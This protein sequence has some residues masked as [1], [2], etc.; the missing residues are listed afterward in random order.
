[1]NHSSTTLHIILGGLAGGLAGGLVVFALSTN[2]VDAHS[3][4][5]AE[6]PKLAVDS[7]VGDDPLAQRMN[8]LE[9]DV[10]LLEGQLMRM[11]EEV[12]QGPRRDVPPVD[13]KPV[14]AAFQDPAFQKN[15]LEVL[16]SRE[17]AQ[18]RERAERRIEQAKR[19]VDRRMER[20]TEDLALSP[21]QAQEMG[22][23]L[24]EQDQKVRD[25]FRGFRE[26]GGPSDQEEIRSTM[27][28][29]FGGTRDQLSPVL[30]V[31]QMSQYEESS[32]GII[33]IE[34]NETDGHR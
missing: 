5:S 28:E 9:Q 2:S 12:G 25:Y 30:S 22:R 15:V 18:R 31:D 29:I 16:E 24:L 19:R 3:D 23:I 13:P 10:A 7:V 4:Y 14:A 1:M 17:E 26:S 34:I 20:Y 6:A 32:Q 27:T 33:S 8:S 11:R 21:Y